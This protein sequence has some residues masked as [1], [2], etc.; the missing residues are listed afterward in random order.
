MCLR[1]RALCFAAIAITAILAAAACGGPDAAEIAVDA[2][3]EELK[4]L[5]REQRLE[6]VDDGQFV[7]AYGDILESLVVSGERVGRPLGPAVETKCPAASSDAE[8]IQA[9]IELV[10]EGQLAQ[11]QQQK[12]ETER[13]LET[14]RASSPTTPPAPTQPAPATG[15][16]RPTLT[17]VSLAI[18]AP[19]S[20]P[21]VSRSPSAAKSSQAIQIDR[22][23]TTHTTR[24]E[25]PESKAQTESRLTFDKSL[26]IHA[27]PNGLYI[28]GSKTGEN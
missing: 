13:H 9:R 10:V 18:T 14:S 1:T 27:E 22:T 28:V 20:S 24:G 3:C 16:S 17:P 8:R 15:S 26:F 19:S 5:I 6:R 4:Y 11:L 25:V 2:F 12:T 21:Q 23:N 7:E